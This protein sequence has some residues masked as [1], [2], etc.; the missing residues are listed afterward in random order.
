LRDGELD[1]CLD[2]G[3]LVEEIDDFPPFSLDVPFKL[4]T[5][6]GEIV[7]EIFNE[8]RRALMT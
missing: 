2:T 5:A 3:V 4:A 6:D 8:D 7:K 1:A